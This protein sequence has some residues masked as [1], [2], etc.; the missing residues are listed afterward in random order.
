MMFWTETVASLELMPRNCG[1]MNGFT[2]NCHPIK[3]SGRDTCLIFRPSRPFK[4]SLR[5]F[6]PCKSKCGEA[7][8]R[9]LRDD[10]SRH[11]PRQRGQRLSYQAR[12]TARPRRIASTA[13][14][15]VRLELPSSD[16]HSLI[17]AFQILSHSTL[18]PNLST[19]AC[20]YS[21]STWEAARI[22]RISVR[23]FSAPPSR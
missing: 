9:A 20:K 14:R 21:P 22:S 2:H 5:G 8:L 13:S 10:V 11:L 17:V 18:R 1:T 3:L 19:Q 15:S 7:F 4:L 12:A 23:C 16:S 6:S